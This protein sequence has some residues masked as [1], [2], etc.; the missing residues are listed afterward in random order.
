MSEV[1]QIGPPA[2]AE[3]PLEKLTITSLEA[4]R[5]LT[6]PLRLQILELMSQPVTVK[7]IAK[8]L[9]MPATKLYYHVGLLEE[10]GLIRVVE[11]RVDSGIIEKKYQVTAKNYSVDR[12]LL[13]IHKTDRSGLGEVL[14]NMIEGVS[15][16]IQKGLD[17]GL[18]KVGD[19][20]PAHQRLILRRSF[21]KLTPEQA[22]EFIEKMTSM[23]EEYDAQNKSKK[24]QHYSLFMTFHLHSKPEL[25]EGEDE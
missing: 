3:A 15:A 1:S 5:V 10:H 23:L 9:E 25:K 11:T 14:G 7:A 20:H 2:Q 13:E 21:V 6:D 4:L 18:I 19:E 8:A 12:K 17:S 24:A 22:E 16:D